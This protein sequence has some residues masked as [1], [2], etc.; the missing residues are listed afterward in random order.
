MQSVDICRPLGAGEQ[1]LWLLDQAH[2]LH[3]AL[4]AQIKGQFTV[5]QLQPVF[6]LVQRRH[7]LL[8]VCIVLDEAERSWFVEHSACI[9]LR[10]VQRYPNGTYRILSTVRLARTRNPI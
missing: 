2:P 7:P 9:P 5:H 10:I 1:L 4:T 6:N 3:F 8:R